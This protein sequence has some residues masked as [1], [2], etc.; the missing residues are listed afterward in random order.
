MN[1]RNYRYNKIYVLFVWNLSIY[2][3]IRYYIY[4]YIYICTDVY[5]SIWLNLLYI[6]IYI[7]RLG[8]ALRRY[9]RRCLRILA[10]YSFVRTPRDACEQPEHVCE[11]ITRDP[12]VSCSA[13]AAALSEDVCEH[14]EM[15]ANTKTIWYY[16]A[17][18]IW[19][20]QMNQ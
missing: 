1:Y 20:I 17:Y 14:P 2:I 16:I 4:I 6:Y 8:D 5:L 9:A 19:Y 10:K 11:H 18:V 7:I 12:R 3:S 13:L 15:F